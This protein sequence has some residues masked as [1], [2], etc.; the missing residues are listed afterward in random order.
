MTKEK[1][2]RRDERVTLV[3]ILFLQNCDGL[4]LLQHCQVGGD[5]KTA[6]RDD[7][8]VYPMKRLGSCFSVR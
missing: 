4:F 7:T 3:C 6:K 1:E 8:S 5:A 2:M